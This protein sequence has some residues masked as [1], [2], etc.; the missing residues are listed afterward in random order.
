MIIVQKVVEYMWGRRKNSLN[1]DVA[2][3]NEK[4]R[5]LAPLLLVCELWRAAALVF[6]C[7]NC[8]V[9]INCFSRAVEVDF[10]AWP[11]DFLYPWFRRTLL[12]KKVTVRVD[13]WRNLCDNTFVKTIVIPQYE[14]VVFPSATTLEIE[15]RETDKPTYKRDYSGPPNNREQMVS[16]A[17]SLMQLV[18]AATGVTIVFVS[19]NKST[20]HFNQ[21]YDTLVSE[22]CQGRVDTIQIDSLVASTPPVLN[23]SS[24]VGLTSIH[25]GLRM[26]R[27]PFASL[28]Y[29]NAKTLRSVTI[30]FLGEEEWHSLIYGGTTTP[31]VY[32][33]LT[34]LRLAVL[35]MLYETTWSAI[36]DIIPFPALSVLSVDDGYPFDDDLLFRGNGATLQYLHLPF[37][38]IVKNV[39]GRFNVLKRSGVT[40]MSCISFPST[41]DYLDR[42]PNAPIKQQMSHIL[43]VTSRVIN[44]SDAASFQIFGA[45]LCAPRMAILQHL[46]L[47]LSSLSVGNIIKLVAALPSLVSLS[48]GI[49]NTGT[50]VE[51]IPVSEHPS[52]LHTK[53]Y[54]LSKNF[55]MLRVPRSYNTSIEA[56]AY[57]AMLIAVLCPNFVQ[58]DL[59]SE[60][61]RDFGREIAWASVNDTFEPYADAIRRLIYKKQNY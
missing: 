27:A 21:L 16:F 50:E 48:C 9:Y 57:T 31:A 12:V 6:I 24:T 52:H 34:T 61:R 3:H 33:E 2:K 22:L 25:Q 40:K 43:E 46:S 51:D 53:Y 36:E 54:P 4:K 18:P 30:T 55:R 49:I 44:R 7:D 5:V 35:A 59:P 10:P 32:S 23:L 11:A 26:R 28:A 47:E 1:L 58:V 20:P 38:A 45:L 15:L 42:L 29:R 56:V 8:A 39:L 17:R 41:S 37:I 60:Q 13:I 19:T 14:G